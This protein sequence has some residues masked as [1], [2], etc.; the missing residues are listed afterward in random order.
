MRITCRD[1]PLDRRVR[2]RRDVSRRNAVP[3][4]RIGRPP[5]FDVL[6]VI[7]LLVVVEATAVAKLEGSSS[8]WLL[9]TLGVV[10]VVPLAWRRQA[11]LLV[12]AISGCATFAALA[13][14][15]SPG[16]L[17]LGPLIALYTVATISPRR[18]SLAAGVVTL[19]GVTIGVAVGQRHG[20]GWRSFVFPAV[21]V[22]ACWLVGDNLRV[23]RA[24]I[25]E[26][27]AK[28]RRADADREAAT[29]RAAS[30]ER[31]RIAR[32]LHDVVV[33]HVSVIAV[34]AGAARMRSEHDPGLSDYTQVLAAV[35]S[36]ARQAL[37]ELRQLLGILR[38][39]GEPAALT[40]L[41]GL[42]QLDQL[43]D[44]VR[45]TGLPVSLRVVGDPY[46][47]PPAVELSAYRIVQ[48]ALTNALKHGGAMPTTVLLRY[49]AE[50]LDI[51]V[52]DE[53][54]TPAMADPAGTVGQGLV[55]MR[56][57]VSM[58]GGDFTAGPR[59]E[60]GF[61][62]RARI[63]ATD[64]RPLANPD[65]PSNPAPPSR[66]LSPTDPRA[67]PRPGPTTTSRS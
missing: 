66:S 6:L 2:Y 21:T 30:E 47:L 44:D 52:T 39:D 61:R 36:A 22:A 32:E 55:G 53:G 58:F 48:E 42:D 65:P 23:R 3:S 13:V 33:H 18:V 9:A 54:P 7:M 34:Q 29:A 51:E 40:P 5:L 49:G 15:G 17:A 4:S 67:V 1:D 50:D 28:A 45:Q 11:P 37:G 46:H 62:V 63:P 27:E 31:A 56:E 59:P 43:L 24:Y 19:V 8:R 35:E 26:L 10:A 60:G 64:R 20:L 38:H 16:P 57:R 25:A 14:H 41:P 12:W